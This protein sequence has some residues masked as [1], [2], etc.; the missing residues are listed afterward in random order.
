M[1]NQL[2]KLASSLGV[3]YFDTAEDYA[4]GGSERQLGR[5][6]AALSKDANVVPQSSN[7]LSAHSLTQQSACHVLSCLLMHILAACSWK[8]LFT[9]CFLRTLDCPPPL[10]GCLELALTD[11]FQLAA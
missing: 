7:P 3:N 5:A 10:Y 8:L 9:R 2:T 6:V 4:K 1:A 11:G